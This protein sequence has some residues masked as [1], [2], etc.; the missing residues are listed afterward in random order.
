[1]T[2]MP[3]PSIERT[4][5]GKPGRATQSNVRRLN[6]LCR[7]LLPGEASDG[8]GLSA[9]TEWF[10]EFAKQSVDQ[11]ALQANEANRAF[12]SSYAAISLPNHKPPRGQS[13]EE[14]ARTVHELREN[15]RQRNH[16]LVSALIE[17]GVVLDETGAV[18]MMRSIKRA[19]DPKNILNPGKI[20]AM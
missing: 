5:S 18:D 6:A 12:F 8:N 16:A 3:N 14:F 11:I 9:Q 20:F 19:L 7:R 10:H 1:M 4:R 2:A 15:E 17:S 13:P